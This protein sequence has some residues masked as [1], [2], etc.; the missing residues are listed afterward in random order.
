MLLNIDPD[1]APFDY[2]IVEAV[3]FVGKTRRG[4]PPG[5]WAD[6]EDINA[7]FDRVASTAMDMRQ[8][9]GDD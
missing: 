3:C 9:Q 4:A 6:D 2:E 5:S 8:E 1:R 7:P